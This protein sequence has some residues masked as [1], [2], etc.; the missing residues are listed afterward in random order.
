MLINYQTEEQKV[1]NDIFSLLLKVY[2]KN[3]SK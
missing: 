2:E 1:M 3:M